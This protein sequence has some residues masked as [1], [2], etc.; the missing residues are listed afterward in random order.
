MAINFKANGQP[1][2]IVTIFIALLTS[3]GGMIFGVLYDQDVATDSSSYDTGQI[4][5]ML[6]MEDFLQRFADIREGCNANGMNCTTYEFSR[7]REGLI[8]GLLSIGTLCGA[9]LGAPIADKLGRRWAMSIECIVTTIG[10]IVQ[11]TAFH[12]W[13]QI[14]VGRLIAGLGV[15]ALSAAVPMY[16]S[17][18][19]VA[20]F[21]GTA[22]ACY[23]LAITF[24]ILLA[25]CFCYGTRELYSDASWRIIVGLGMVLT[26]I[27]GCGI[28]LLPESPR[29][30]MKANKP[31]EAK[32]ALERIRG[33]NTDFD[34]TVVDH[35]FLEIASRIKMEQQ[36]ES[37]FWRSWV[38]CF[39]GHP[40]TKKLVYRTFLGM[41]IQSLQQLTGANYF[42]YYGATIFQ[43]VG[44]E[45]SYIT[46]IILG[47]V[48]FVCTFAS[49]YV[50][51][52]FGRRKPLIIGGLW[53]CVWLLIFASVGVARPPETNEGMGDLMIVSACLFIASYA[54][55][56]GPACWIVTGE[57]FPMRTRARQAAIATASNWTWN[58]LISFFSPFITGDIG[59]GYGYVFAGCNL[60]AAFFVFF[61]LYETAGLTLEAVDEMYSTDGLKAYQSGGWTP[62]GYSSRGEVMETSKVEQYHKDHAD[63]GE[64]RF[65]DDEERVSQTS[66]HQDVSR[67]V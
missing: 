1:L 7:V 55:T 19:V 32:R 22:V 2:G 31:D 51:E 43:S 9:L 60:F 4:S 12:V 13:Q 45:D 41:F 50:L 59:Y 27:L 65:D 54:T 47:V 39:A 38:E 17:E 49:L 8:V 25:Y 67:K 44:I 14:A 36:T 58:F 46:Q 26:F 48:N 10:F 24:G 53:Q 20:A 34:S 64:K 16:M 3:V 42:F 18:C 15:G 29:W 28:W 6:L 56:W 33:V 40:G 21:R 37:P 66:G 61:F 23:Q 63:N 62:P 11:I 57:T 30:L 52:N 5:D 35:D